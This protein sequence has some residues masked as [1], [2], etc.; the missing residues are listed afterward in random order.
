MTKDEITALLNKHTYIEDE[1]RNCIEEMQRLTDVISCER[2][3]KATIL[4]GMPG[5]TS[6]LS[7]PTYRKAQKIL[8]EYKSEIKRIERKQ[9]GLFVKRALVCEL[10][11]ILS[12]EERQVIE[13]RHFKKYR[14]WMVASQTKYNERYCYKLRDAAMEKMQCYLKEEKKLGSLVQ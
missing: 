8:D 4:S 2:D 13:L 12:P 11:D 9:R 6:T 7:D 5:N 14:W 10:I 3:I 1:I